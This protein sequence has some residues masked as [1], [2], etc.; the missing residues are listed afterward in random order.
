M[1]PELPNS[2]TGSKS[3]ASSGTA[4]GLPLDMQMPAFD[5]PPT[6][7]PRIPEL[8]A[9]DLDALSGALNP[10][11]GNG[12]RDPLG[13]SAGGAGVA[14]MTSVG[15]DE[16]ESESQ[17]APVKQVVKAP[18]DQLFRVKCPVCESLTYARPAQVGK[19][20]RCGDCHSTITVPPPPKPKVKY[21]PN[22]EEAKTFAFQPADDMD[23]S[24]PAD[25]FRKSADQYLAAAEKAIEASEPEHDWELPPISLWLT[26]VVRVLRDPAAIGQWI[27]VSS[28]AAVPAA[29]AVSTG[30][31]IAVLAL[32]IIGFLLIAVL[33]ANGFAILEAVANEE[34]TVS[35]WP[36]FDLFAWLGPLFMAL[37]AGLVAAAPLGL[38]MNLLAPGLLSVGA[39]M[40]SIYFL[41]P[42]VLLSMLDSESVMQPFSAS[43]SKSVTRSSQHW[44]TMYT[45]SGFLFFGLFVVYVVAAL[46]PPVA[47]VVLRTFATSGAVF[48]YF[49]MLG[50]LAFVIGH[51][52]NAKPMKNDVKREP[53]SSDENKEA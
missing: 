32:F 5:S 33:V 30:S 27:M 28:M 3:T 11:R 53:K 18:T 50:Q 39:T 6:K 14:G 37:A 41:Y 29:I 40:L 47:G 19:T 23:A 20:I 44:M 49:A 10:L 52:V 36:L 38:P 24:R 45:A 7:G 13:T 43:V 48:C 46:M 34:E 2:G 42:F 17:S 16:D 22:I 12:E 4:N 8:S 25:P 35:E 9:Q 1:L 21:E 31:S 26:N 51:S 15:F